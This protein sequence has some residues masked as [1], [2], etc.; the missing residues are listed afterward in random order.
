MLTEPRERK[1]Q[2]VPILLVRAAGLEPARRCHREILSPLM[3]RQAIEIEE[4]FSLR[5]RYVLIF[6]VEKIPCVYEQ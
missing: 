4:L 1:I 6:R 5:R 3:V 2:E